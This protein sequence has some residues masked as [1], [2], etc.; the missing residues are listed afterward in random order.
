MKITY[1]IRTNGCRIAWDAANTQREPDRIRCWH[2]RSGEQRTLDRSPDNVCQPV[3][4]TMWNCM[5]F[6]GKTRL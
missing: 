4:G 6:N 5:R 1:H 3:V 2:Y